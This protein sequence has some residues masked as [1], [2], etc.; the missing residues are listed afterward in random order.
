MLGKE[1]NYEESEVPHYDLPDPLIDGDGK[2]V[3][4]AQTWRDQR[5]GEI[6]E[7]FATEVYGLVPG[8]AATSWEEAA[9]DAVALGGLARRR[10]ITIRVS[11][12]GS[13]ARLE[14]LL[15]LPATTAHAVPVF[16]G[17]NYFGNHAIQPDPGILLST[18]WMR[19]SRSNHI[20]D[21]RATEASR[22]RQQSRWPVNRILERGYAVATLYHG[23]LDPDFDDG[24]ANGV[25][26]LFYATGQCAPDNDEWGALGA[27]A[28]GLSRALDYLETDVDVDHRRVAILGHSRLGKA[29]LWA[30]ASDERFAAVISN[31]SGC[32]GAALS[33]RCFGETVA[34]INGRFP[35]WFCDRFRRYNDREAQLPIDQ[36]QLLALVAPR[37]LYVASAAA[38]LWADPRGEFLGA[39]NAH[40]VYRLHGAEGLPVNEM[41]PPDEPVSG[42]IGYHVRSGGHDITGYDWDRYL[43]F[44]DRNL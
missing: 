17:L 22:G 5:R 6:L 11:G 34:L 43:D 31:N 7:Q 1:P 18:A 36:H 33:R 40:P 2:P 32:G 3:A 13:D 26:P 35:H 25:H 19:R 41:P 37:P 23:D 39:L 9:D 29:A 12:A 30:G 28:W 24:Y 14:L 10:Q 27:W 21:H 4:D 16:L 42:T 15:Y 38:D 44:V 20:V 8:P